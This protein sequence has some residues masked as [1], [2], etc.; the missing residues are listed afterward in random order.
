ML[1]F[2]GM[3]SPWNLKTDQLL[4]FYVRSKT[5]KIRRFLTKRGLLLDVVALDTS[6]LSDFSG[7]MLDQKP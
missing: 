3:L 4:W 2:C 6:K 7:F 1:Y 5:S